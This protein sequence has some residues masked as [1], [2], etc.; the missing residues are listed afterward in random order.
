VKHPVKTLAALAI[1]G[2]VAPSAHDVS[3]KD[4]V[5]SIT[6]TVRIQTRAQISDATS[7]GKTNLGGATTN[8]LEGEEYRVSGGVENAVNDPIDFMLRRARL[9]LNFKYGANWKGQFTV[10]AD[11]VDNTGGNTN[12]ALNIR[13][14]WLERGFDLGDGMAAALKFG[15]DKA[16]QNPTD[17]LSSSRKLL[18]NDNASSGY[19]AP[20]GVGIGARFH[21]PIFMIA[22]DL[23]NNTN[24]AK[25][26]GGGIAADSNS[27]EEE[28]FYYGI[29][30]E[31]SFSPDWFIA[32]RADSFVGKEGH[33]LNIG[34]SYGV[35]ADAV[36]ADA[37][38]V[39][40]NPGTPPVGQRGKQS[41][42]AYGLDVMLWMNGLSAFAEYRKGTLES[43]RNDGVAIPNTAPWL[44]GEEVDSEFITIQVG[45]AF[46]IGEEMIEPAIRY[47]IIDNNTDVDEFANY[48]NNAESGGSGTQIDLGVNYYLSGH[49][50]KLS[51]A[52]S[53][54]EAEEGEGD[55]TIIRLQ[56]QINF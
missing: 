51:L 29:R 13:Y 34:L 41:T 6:P 28:G 55:A 2:V 1:L 42:S 40:A 25:D 48:G 45:Y 20:R 30:A 33:G 11:N 37:D 21:H 38:L 32:K 39:T 47:Q 54:W 3:I 23:Q 53:L 52:L 9:G 17:R 24:A 15:L 46:P 50:N 19:L 44:G 27:P 4:D 14:G 5:L 12:R 10:M 16:E 36:L 49:D 56:H 31:F 35:N 43:E 26:T 7:A 8:G 22:A 18:P